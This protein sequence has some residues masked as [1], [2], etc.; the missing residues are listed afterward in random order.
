MTTA[1]TGKAPS[2]C[3]WPLENERAEKR[4]RRRGLGDLVYAQRDDRRSDTPADL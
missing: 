1:P 3:H 4:A 2:R